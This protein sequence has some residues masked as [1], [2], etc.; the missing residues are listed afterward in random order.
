M[1]ENERDFKGMRIPKE[2]WLNSE[3]NFL[4]K[5]LLA[6]IDSLDK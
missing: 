3:M 6:E 1:D 5:G 2:I 4:E